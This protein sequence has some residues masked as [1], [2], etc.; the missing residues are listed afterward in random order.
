MKCAG[1]TAEL[2]PNKAPG[3]PRKWCSE[4]CRKSQY[5]G[6]CV[7]CGKATNGSDGRGRRAPTRC[8]DC[9]SAYLRDAATWTRDRLIAE[10]Q[11]WHDLTGLWPTSGDWAVQKR[12]V[13]VSAALED[14]V[15]ATG[16]WPSEGAVYRR[17]ASWDDFMAAAGGEPCRTTNLGTEGRAAKAAALRAAT[18]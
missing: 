14:F 11:R 18:P 12:S 9:S 15:Q 4:R 8:Q 10:A 5:A 3:P 2:P 13:A 1:C 16:P 7:D 6:R 17:L